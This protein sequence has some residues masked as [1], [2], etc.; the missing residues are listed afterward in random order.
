MMVPTE[1]GVMVV[2]VVAWGDGGDGGD[3]VIVAVPGMGY[4]LLFHLVMFGAP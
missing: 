1:L 4:C 3:V 2:I